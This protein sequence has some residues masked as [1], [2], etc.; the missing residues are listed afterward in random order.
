MEYL[1]SVQN[2]IDD[3]KPSLFGMIQLHTTLG[4]TSAQL[5]HDVRQSSSRSSSSPPFFL[6]RCGTSWPLRRTGTR[7]IYSGR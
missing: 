1:S 7:A 6:L 2:E 3:L 4:E 5:T